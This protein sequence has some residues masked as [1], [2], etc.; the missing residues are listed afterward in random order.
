MQ[1]NGWQTGWPQTSF[2]AIEL[3][4][5]AQETPSQPSISR[6]QYLRPSSRRCARRVQPKFQLHSSRIWIDPWYNYGSFCNLPVQRSPPL[7]DGGSASSN[8]CRVLLPGRDR[9]LGVCCYYDHKK[10]FHNIQIHFYV[11]IVIW[12]YIGLLIFVV[13]LARKLVQEGLIC[14]FSWGLFSHA[15]PYNL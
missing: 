5:H 8:F 4:R 9:F 3:E 7:S 2:L 15:T 6:S 10:S 13:A 14:A 12:A 1:T 11:C